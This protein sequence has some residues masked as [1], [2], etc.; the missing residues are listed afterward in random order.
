MALDES[1]QHAADSVGVVQNRV[2]FLRRN[3]LHGTEGLDVDCDLTGFTP[4]LGEP[5]SL[6]AGGESVGAFSNERYGFAGSAQEL[7]R[8]GAVTPRNSPSDVVNLSEDLERQTIDIKFV[9]AESI[10]GFHSR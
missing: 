3:E 9:M 10:L 7:V 1:G 4:R 5:L 8:E 6:L 2:G